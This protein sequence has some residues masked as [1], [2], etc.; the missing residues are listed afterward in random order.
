MGKKKAKDQDVIKVVMYFQESP[1]V[2]DTL[3][4]SSVNM[5][6]HFTQHLILISLSE[7]F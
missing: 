2:K 3:L 6:L 7:L 4:L 1:F 5:L